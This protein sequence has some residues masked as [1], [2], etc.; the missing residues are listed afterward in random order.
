MKIS[1]NTYSVYGVADPAEAFPDM[2]HRGF[3]GFEMW[4]IEDNAVQPL[5]DAM[6]KYGM[7]LTCFCTDYF[8]LTDPEK[9]PL[10]LQG[11]ASALKKAKAL[12]CKALITQIGDDTGAD[13]TLQ[14]KSIVD[15]LKACL[16][17]LEA[18]GVTLMVEPLNTVKD[19]IGYYLHDSNEGFDIVREVGHPNVR[20][21]FDIYH[22][23][24]MQEP[25]LE[26]IAE[27]FDLIAHFHVAG[28]PERDEKIFENF[29]YRK[30]FEKIDASKFKG[31]VGMELFPKKGQHTAFLDSLQQLTG[32][33]GYANH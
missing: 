17:M 4:M 13:R 12:D 8:Q 1:I 30:A 3:N 15:G 5:A 22:Q 10:Y 29:D 24:H 14:H 7:T 21:L 18:A 19:H 6:K 25:V 23:L 20:L 26:R 32:G 33:K 2:V 16:P 9:R 11:L 31:Y 28:F 27:G